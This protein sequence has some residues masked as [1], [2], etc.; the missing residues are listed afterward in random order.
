MNS[1]LFR[2]RTTLVI[3]YFSKEQHF[4]NLSEPARVFSSLGFVTVFLY[5][6]NHVYVTEDDRT[7]RLEILMNCDVFPGASGLCACCHYRACFWPR[8]RVVESQI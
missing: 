2:Q 1:F 4:L 7:R 8:V 5:F 6:F 3:R